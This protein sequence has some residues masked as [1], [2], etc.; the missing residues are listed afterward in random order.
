ML[1]EFFQP[2]SRV[3]LV[4]VMILL[5]LALMCSLVALGAFLR[6]ACARRR[7]A[8]AIAAQAALKQLFELQGRAP[9]A[10][11][12][13]ELEERYLDQIERLFLLS[14]TAPMLG[15]AGTLIPLGPAL[16]AVSDGALDL[17]SRS[18]IVAF[19]TT[20]IGIVAGG[21]ALVIGSVRRRWFERDLEELE[22]SLPPLGE[23]PCPA[24]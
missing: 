7:P 21:L 2:I 23:A 18:L 24:A 6:E 8:R 5:I 19:D 1:E 10:R 16:Q 11:Y 3:L 22:R 4:P 14:R 20:V 9:A 15:L 12:L 13:E 17:L